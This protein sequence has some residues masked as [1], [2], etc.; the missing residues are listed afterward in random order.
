[1]YVSHLGSMFTLF[2]SGKK[3]TSYQDAGGCDLHR[4]A[5][6]FRLMLR[7][8]IYLPPSQ[9]ETNFISG[10]HTKKDI[11]KTLEAVEK[12]FTLLKKT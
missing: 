4:F 1:M 10:A 8:G 5:R 12:T 9:F 3:V 11:I 2:F 6:Y 7:E